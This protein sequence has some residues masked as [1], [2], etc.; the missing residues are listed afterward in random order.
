MLFVTKLSPAFF[1]RSGR[2]RPYFLVNS[3]VRAGR[4]FSHKNLPAPR[5]EGDTRKFA[6][7]RAGEISSR[8]VFLGAA[9]TRIAIPVGVDYFVESLDAPK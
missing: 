8:R 9:E 2:F 4:R 7:N 1:G 5:R 6:A 3:L